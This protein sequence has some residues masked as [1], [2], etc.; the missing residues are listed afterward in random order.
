MHPRIARSVEAIRRSFVDNLFY[1]TGRTLG[2][3][4]HLDLCTA[5]AFTIRDRMLVRMIATERLYQRRGAKTV[6]YL[7]AEFLLGPHFA[8][9]MLNLKL[10]DNV[11]EAKSMRMFRSGLQLA[12][13]TE[14]KE[15]PHT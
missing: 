5:L 7:S 3:A 8:N 6:A 2:T 12:G 15:Q 11:R 13:I 1:V 9:N 10:T 14:D 4:T